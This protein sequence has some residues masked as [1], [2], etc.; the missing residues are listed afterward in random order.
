MTFRVTNII[1]WITA[2]L[3]VLKIILLARSFWNI[4]N[5][6]SSFIIITLRIICFIFTIINN[7][8]QVW[9]IIFTLS[10]TGTFCLLQF[11]IFFF[12]FPLSYLLLF[13]I[14]FIY[15][16]WRYFSFMR[17]FYCK[18]LLW[19]FLFFFLTFTVVFLIFFIRWI[20]F[21]LNFCTFFFPY[22]GLFSFFKE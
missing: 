1:I 16:V 15:Y 8:L 13:L 2:L 11:E 10:S 21:L 20:E 6:F 7:F 22:G 9:F 19:F 12:L 14:K 18:C 3:G 5:E 4:W 17:L